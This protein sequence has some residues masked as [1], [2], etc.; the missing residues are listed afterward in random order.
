M[1]AVYFAFL[2]RQQ[3]ETRLR[4][5][6][7]LE[8]V[9]VDNAQ[10][11]LEALPGAEAAIVPGA[12]FAYSA[13]F[14]AG[15]RERGRSLRWLQLIS[16][17]HEGLEEHG[18]PEWVT[19]TD[20][21]G[22]HGVPCAEHAITLLLALTRQLPAMMANQARG[23]WSRK[24]TERL[25]SVEGRTAAVLGMGHIGREFAR[26]AR[27]FGMRVVGVTRHARP[28]P[29]ADEMARVED[30]HAVLAR[31]DAIV[32]T[33][34]GTASTVGLVGVAAL[35]ASKPGALLVNVGRGN[36]VDTPALV[37]ALRSGRLAGAGLDVMDPEPVPPGHPLWSMANVIISP[38][39][40]GGGSDLARE[41]MAEAIAANVERF[42]A[43]RPLL[44]QITLQAGR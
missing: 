42:M 43:G 4:A 26:R 24:P 2:A 44:N 22:S 23:E 10:A 16:A 40:A 13:A 14:V 32:V 20:N 3:I 38:H 34:P 41:R 36:V 39:C 27:A 17:G 7:G 25:A 8:L 37:E 31:S 1:R 9:V 33:L 12:G 5:I 29:L 15:L 35:A 11:C 21:G 6:P 19:I 18:A 30:L 28:D